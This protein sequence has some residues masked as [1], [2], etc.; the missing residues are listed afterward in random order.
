MRVDDDTLHA[1]VGPYGKPP[2]VEQA[3]SDGSLDLHRLLD[4]VVDR[5]EIVDAD[6][7]HWVELAKAVR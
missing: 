4:T 5:Y 1:A 2:P 7:A 3:E 6:G